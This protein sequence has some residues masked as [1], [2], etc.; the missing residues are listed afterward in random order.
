MIQLYNSKSKAENI[1]LDYNANEKGKCV[2]VHFIFLL[3][4]GREI[5]LPLT[6]RF[7]VANLVKYKMDLNQDSLLVNE[8]K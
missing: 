8:T 1:I 5:Q 6:Q 7:A 3:F 4:L 2:L